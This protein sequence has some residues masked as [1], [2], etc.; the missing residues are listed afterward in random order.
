HQ[1]ARRREGRAL[2]DALERG[3]RLG[4][5]LLARPYHG[6][7]GL[8]HGICEALQKH[9]YPVIPIESLPIDDAT[10][11]RLYGAEMAAGEIS[12]PLSI[13]DVWA[14]SF[15]ENSSRKLWGAKFAARHPNLVA[16]ELSSFKCGQDAPLYSV[17]EEIVEWSGTPF[18]YFRDIDE[19]NP[20]GSIKL[21]IETIDYFLKRMHEQTRTEPAPQGLPQQAVEARE[22]GFGTPEE[23]QDTEPAVVA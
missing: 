15:C 12:S 19:N 14:D 8:N 3:N 21:R 17:V 5:V 13:N 20:A 1:T 22:N 4:V 11:G 23:K 16:L 9:G 7:P 2:L 10:L 6:D 18:F